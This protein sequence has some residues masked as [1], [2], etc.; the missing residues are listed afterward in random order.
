MRPLEY[1]AGSDREVQFAGEAA[2]ISLDFPG[3]DTDFSLAFRAGRV[4]SPAHGLDVK[5]RYPLV[6][7]FL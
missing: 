2:I 1:G 7:E 5:A 6:G 4:T 3:L